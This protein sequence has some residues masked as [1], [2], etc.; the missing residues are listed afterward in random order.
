M[1]VLS[2]VVAQSILSD[3]QL[4]RLD[5]LARESGLFICATKEI[6]VQIISRAMSLGTLRDCNRSPSALIKSEVE[7][8]TI[9]AQQ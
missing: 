2:C 5:C 1:C 7:Q 8:G 9:V 6:Q 3:K 4:A